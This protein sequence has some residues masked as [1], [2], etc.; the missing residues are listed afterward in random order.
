M[1]KKLQSD[2]PH[3]AKPDSPEAGR[4][5]LP[6]L[7]K[8]LVICYGITAENEAMVR[9]VFEHGIRLGSSRGAVRFPG[10][11][12]VTALHLGTRRTARIANKLADLFVNDPDAEIGHL[13]VEGLASTAGPYDWN[14]PEARQ[15]LKERVKAAEGHCVTF[16][17]SLSGRAESRLVN[18]L[19]HVAEDAERAKGFAVCFV[20][21]PQAFAQP[22]TGIGTDA[23]MIDDCDPS[24]GA[25]MAFSATSLAAQPFHSLGLGRVM[26]D[27]YLSDNKARRVYQP[28]VSDMLDTR[29]M[30][31]LKGQGLSNEQIG[32]VFWGMART[33][34]ARRLELL[35][36]P[37]D[38]ILKPGWIETYA[39]RLDLD[40]EL[41]Q[42]FLGSDKD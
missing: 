37:R 21:G 29:F 1:S 10:K 9:A 6:A 42:Q 2:T 35:P 15:V 17:M 12:N 33:T 39:K 41:I 8:G 30:W 16:S 5:K 26:C 32:K 36:P 14:S 25:A 19:G 31:L 23:V 34:V 13:D 24:P 22:L 3:G 20:K 38:V 18:T 11:R 40:E 28:F 27:V 7:P 4:F